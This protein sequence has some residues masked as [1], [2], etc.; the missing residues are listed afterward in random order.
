MHSEN[1][2]SDE[3]SQYWS[4]L[5]GDV[6]EQ[7]ALLPD[8]SVQCVVTSPP[9]W[10]L[11]DYGTATWEGGDPSCQHNARSGDL[12]FTHPIS[13][14]Q[15]SNAGSAGSAGEKC[16]HCGAK[17]VDAQIGLELSPAAYV[18]ALVGVFREVR[19]VLADDGVVWLNLGDSYCNTDKW[20][21]GGLNTGKQTV[22]NDG[23]IPSWTVRRRKQPFGMKPKDLVGI[24]WMTAFALRD[25]GWYL[26]RDI[27]WH[28]P[29]P[30]PESVRD[31]CTSSHE[32]IFHLSKS[33]RYFYDAEAVAELASDAMVQQIEQGYDGLG[34]KDYEGAGVQNPSTVKG[35]IIANA[36]KRAD[37][38]GG[39]KYNGKNES[40]GDRTKIGF[41]EQW[42][43]KHSDWSVYT[44]RPTRN[45]R[46]VWTIPTQPYPE[47]HFATFPATIPERCIKAGSRLGDTILDPFCGSGT[48]GQVA[49]QLGRS[50][51]GIELNPTYAELARRRI[52]VAAPLFASEV[53]PALGDQAD[54]P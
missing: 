53:S 37:Q 27:I 5:V 11:R 35:R 32:Y 39:K 47:A 14:K 20:G 2:I 15:S 26:R 41:N 42:D 38:F 51:I 17:R 29:N 24:P 21:G 4:V 34:L 52:D 6:L 8:A 18:A 22:A 43:G 45:L 31:R 28:K 30:M 44:G 10:G 23:S 13:A 12:R 49:I 7:L 19:R 46:S 48:T 40:S 36:R 16:H 25:D 9:Y 54:R 1:G 50:F 3:A 33:E